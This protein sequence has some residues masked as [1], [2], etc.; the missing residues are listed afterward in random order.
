MAAILPIQQVKRGLIDKSLNV[1]TQTVSVFPQCPI[2]MPHHHRCANTA[3][4]SMVTKM[5]KSQLCQGVNPQ[6]GATAPLTQLRFLRAFYHEI[7]GEI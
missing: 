4:V 2:I 3:F 6:G 1:I 5:Q 7:N